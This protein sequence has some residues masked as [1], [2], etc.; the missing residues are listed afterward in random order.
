[1][2]TAMA[3]MNS[4]RRL[5]RLLGLSVL[6]LRCLSGVAADSPV[7]TPAAPDTEALAW[8]YTFG[9]AIPADPHL[10]ERSA[11][12][13]EALKAYLDLGH[14]EEAAKRAGEIDDWRRGM[15]YCDLAVVYAQR[16]GASLMLQHYLE[17]ARRYRDTL[18]G[19]NADWQKDRITARIGVAQVQ[20]GL[21]DEATATIAGVGDP[22]VA[23]A[24]A[25]MLS[26]ITDDA[27]YESSLQKLTALGEAPTLE[28]QEAAVRACIRILEKHAA[29]F[30]P[31]RLERVS[32]CLS[33]V[34]PK[35]PA[36]LQ[37]DLR[38]AAGQALLAAGRRELGLQIL[39]ETRAA[40]EARGLDARFDVA[41]L[42]EIA[43][44]YRVAAADASQA[45]AVLGQAAAL[46]KDR[47][48]HDLSEGVAATVALAA[49]YA[50]C[51]Q[52]EP[53]WQHFRAALAGT[54]RQV[55][56]RP[57]HMML[58]DVCLAIGRARYALPADVRQT[59]DREW[60]RRGDPW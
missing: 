7:A 57:R 34:V 3:I 35:L 14:I 29:D 25:E 50:A 27:S 38:T 9:T 6:T 44:V 45:E 30:T 59:L 12:Q 19:H 10:S 37:C 41:R 1:M 39:A 60:N 46:L 20:A 28:A 24:Q 36:L 49:G 18:E 51:G 56:G 16:E 32:A 52:V 54:G 43:R 8:A 42:A 5:G 23:Q 40:M 47:P 58:A 21:T 55:N 31:E 26:R 2:T 11:C 13:Y 33:T 22:T 4:S 17:Q 48:P 15:L 53:A